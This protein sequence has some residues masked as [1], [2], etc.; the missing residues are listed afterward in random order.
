LADIIL[1]IQLSTESSNQPLSL[2]YNNLSTPG[3]D[4][5]FWKHFKAV[6]KDK[7]YLTNI[8]NIANACIN[9]DHWLS[10]FKTSLSIIISKFN[11]MAYNSL[12]M[13]QPIILL[14]TLEKLIKKVIGARLQF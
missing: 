3:L 2:Y 6:I 13:F 4:W 1:N 12:K 14:N 7:R 10:Y 5:V 8:V 11:E 9:I